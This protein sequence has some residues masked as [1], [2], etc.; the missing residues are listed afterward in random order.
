MD[1]FR[2]L[3]RK[4][5]V[6]DKV[7]QRSETWNVDSLREVIEANPLNLGSLTWNEG[8]LTHFTSC[9]DFSLA[10]SDE[11]N[12]VSLDSN[13]SILSSCYKHNKPIQQFAADRKGKCF[14]FAE[15]DSAVIH[16]GFTSNPEL[17]CNF[18]A[19][20]PV[21]CLA[22]G[23][24]AV[25]AGLQTGAIAIFPWC[26][27]NHKK[28]SGKINTITFPA[29]IFEKTPGISHIALSPIDD[30]MA[31]IIGGILA[32]CHED[33]VSRFTLYFKEINKLDACFSFDGKYLAA[34]G[35]SYNAVFDF[36]GGFSINNSKGA[37]T[38]YDL[39]N[40]K[41]LVFDGESCWV[42]N[43]IWSSYNDKLICLLKLVSRNSDSV[44]QAISIHSINSIRNGE[45]KPESVTQIPDSV[46]LSYL[47]TVRPGRL[48]LKFSRKNSEEADCWSV[49]KYIIYPEPA[50]FENGKPPFQIIPDENVESTPDLKDIQNE[51]D[52]KVEEL[53][54]EGIEDNKI[55]EI[56]TLI[57]MIGRRDLLGT[58]DHIN[59]I[60]QLGEKAV[61]HLIPLLDS[62]DVNV[63]AD[64]AIL[65]G[66]IGAKQAIPKLRTL[67]KSQ[68]AEVHQAAL[69]ALATLDSKDSSSLK[70]DRQNPYGQ[71]SSL[72]T[73]IIQGKQNLYSPEILHEFCSETVHEMPGLNF[74]SNGENARAWGMLGSLVFKSISPEWPGGSYGTRTCPE[75]RMCYE[76]ALRCEPGDSWWED[77]V[78]KFS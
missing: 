23:K 67:S 52:E 60:L 77:W 28:L 37:V 30:R 68:W 47:G 44:S 42:E 71:I 46:S 78:K 26:K 36:N 72:W 62:E 9:G 70:L 63:V 3:F 7:S 41:N 19:E 16:I 55:P 45:L 38:I 61:P 40:G 10:V 25:Y 39:E 5:V 75:A 20:A 73:A 27:D 34:A 33:E 50:S 8:K 65:L 64:A 48:L 54:N 17:N 29:N 14:A 24:N 32:V 35:G 53:T 69:T 66:K 1:F 21:S 15:E 57:S 43:V 31:F 6:S 74:S 56:E 4:P 11:I 59:T 12:V 18:D 22:I 76:E 58:S 2:Q 13:G 49:G 51:V